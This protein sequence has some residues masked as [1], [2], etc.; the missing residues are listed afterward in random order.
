MDAYQI[1]VWDRCKEL[2][3]HCAVTLEVKDSIYITDDRGHAL[4]G[5]NTVDEVRAF[6]CGYEHCLGRSLK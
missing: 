3:E 1:Q 4:G 2:A 6:L 5:F